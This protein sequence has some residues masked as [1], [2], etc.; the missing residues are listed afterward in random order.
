MNGSIV[1]YIEKGT[2]KW[3]YYFNKPSKAGEFFKHELAKLNPTDILSKSTVNGSKVV[4]I[5]DNTFLVLTTL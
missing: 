1:E 3:H 5:A 2:L 4:T